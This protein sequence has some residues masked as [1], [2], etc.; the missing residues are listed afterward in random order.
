ML[1][2]V[3]LVDK[4][5][6]KCIY[7]GIMADTGCFSYNSSKPRTFEIVAELL[8]FNINKEALDNKY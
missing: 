1:N 5:I 3:N 2:N 7:A 4:E 6:A 8:R